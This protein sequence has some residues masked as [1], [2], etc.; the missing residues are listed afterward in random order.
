[1]IYV[2]RIV[3]TPHS[4][5]SSEMSNSQVNSDFRGNCLTD[6]SYCVHFVVFQKAFEIFC[7]CG[8]GVPTIINTRG[9]IVL[10]YVFLL[11]WTQ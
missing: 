3:T 2:A 9:K 10:C 8:F 1:M 7:A 4:E 5:H 11:F 6:G